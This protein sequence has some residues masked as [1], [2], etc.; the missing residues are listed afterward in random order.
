M[1][2][3][4]GAEQLITGKVLKIKSAITGNAYEISGSSEEPE[5]KPCKYRLRKNNTGWTDEI[6]S[7]D[8]AGIIENGGFDLT[9]SARQNKH[10]EWLE[11][12]FTPHPPEKLPEQPNIPE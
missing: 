11:R 9:P 8:L 1:C 5:A 3:I 7:N 2:S 10:D 6:H 4:C 12:H